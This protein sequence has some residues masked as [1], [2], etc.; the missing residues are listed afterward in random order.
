MISGSGSDRQGTVIE[1]CFLCQRPGDPT[2]FACNNQY[3][4]ASV[5]LSGYAVVP[6][7]NL[8]DNEFVERLKQV[9]VEYV[10]R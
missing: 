1:H 3:G 9:A 4:L 8:L 6:L 2:L 5:C 7:E 10:E